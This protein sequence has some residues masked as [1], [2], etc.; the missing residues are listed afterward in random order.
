MWPFKRHKKLID[1][2]IAQVL[3]NYTELDI[4][5]TR[6][7]E[8]VKFLGDL[9]EPN[10]AIG[11]MSAEELAEEKKVLAKEVE[12]AQRHEIPGPTIQ[13]KI[14]VI[15]KGDKKPPVKQPSV[16]RRIIDYLVRVGVGHWVL[17]QDVKAAIL[18]GDAV[19]SGGG[20][21]SRSIKRLV[22]LDLIEFEAEGAD[23]ISLT[24]FGMAQHGLC[25]FT[26]KDYEKAVASQV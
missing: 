14:S 9:Q 20:H 4:R 21:F 13:C 19:S 17:T 7:E 3:K 22:A 10:C 24:D 2:V 12:E 6:L 25:W 8:T 26:L 11:I 1:I 18:G 5:I 15:K 23:A 16:P